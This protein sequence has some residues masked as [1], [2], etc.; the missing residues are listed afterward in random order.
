MHDEGRSEA[1]LC[2]DCHWNPTPEAQDIQFR[3]ETRGEL[4]G[5]AVTTG[6]TGVEEVKPPKADQRVLTADMA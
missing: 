4:E 2:S 6:A 5:G 1:P 3:K